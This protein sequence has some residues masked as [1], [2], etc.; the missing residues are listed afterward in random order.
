MLNRIL[1]TSGLSP[2]RLRATARS[3]VITLRVMFLTRSVRST[4]RQHL[5]IHVRQTTSLR[6]LT[7]AAVIA[8]SLHLGVSS[9][10]NGGPTTLQTRYGRI[11]IDEQGF[12]TSITARQSGKEYCPAGHPSPLLSLHE[13]EQPY[14]QLIF[15]KSAAF[16]ADKQQLELKYPNGATAVVKVDA[17]KNYFRF[18]LVSLTPR[19]KVDNIVWGPVHTTISKRIG[20]LIGVVRDNDW[21]IGLYGLD[22][23]TIAGPP[24]DGDCYSMGYYVHS[25]D[26]KKYPLPPDLKEGQKFTIGGDGQSDVAFY[27]RPEEYFHQVFGNGAWLE[28]EFGSTLAYHARDR[29][30]SYVHYFSLLP[31]FHKY[32]RRHMVSDPIPGVDFMGSA[33]ALYACPDDLGLATIETIIKAE[34]LP[35]I[36]HPDGKWIRDP[37]TF[38]PSINWHGPYDKAI[39]YA[40]AIG[41]RAIT[42]ETGESYP[43]LKSTPTVGGASFSDGRKMTG[44]E[45]A[46]MCHN[47][48]LT[49]GGL[50]T[51]TVFLQGGISS[52]VIPPSEHL[53]TVCRTKLAK[54]ISESD[55]EI[56]VTD[57]SFLAEKGTWHWG[58]DSNYLRIGSEMLRYE[59]ISDSPP[60]ILKGIKRGHASKAQ[61]HKAGDEVAKLMQNCYNGFVPDMKLLLDYADWYAALMERSGMD[62]IG[63]DGFESTIYQNHG[64]YGVRVFC[65]RLFETY[66]K[67]TGGR[68]P[69]IYVPSNVF[70]GSWEYMTAC[71]I[72]GGARMF[73]A[74][75]GRR[76]IQGKDVGTAFSNSYF[77]ATLSGPGWHSHWSVYDAENLQAKSIGW[78]ATYVLNM[79]EEVVERTGEK[80][81]IFKALRTWE[82]ARRLNVFTRAQKELL[83]DPDYKFHLEPTGATAFVLHPI[84]EIKI[85]EHA[86][87]EPV[88]VAI[89][90]PYDTQALEFALQ[91]H[92]AVK[93]CIVTLPDGSQIQCDQSMESGQFLIC[94]R[95][96]AYLAD[97]YRKKISDLV[98]DHAAVLPKGESK[99]GV[100]FPGVAK[101]AKV[102]F[103][104]TAWSFATPEKVG[105]QSA[106]L[107]E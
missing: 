68:T 58:D 49:F 107:V 42:R 106:E 73:D 7:V 89:A 59:S 27:S 8:A 75:T 20:D 31:D 81:A 47:H 45:Y 10:A 100:Q 63:F 67:L 46:E 70:A 61:A 72:G 43:S 90:N 36:T 18:Q 78:D 22:D 4:L 26:P 74:A 95:N 103:D 96:Q 6:S 30:Q 101:S 54:D 1:S 28:P 29:R 17:K 79:S 53:Q 102:R 69:Y 2:I 86:G 57:P 65:R 19:G 16:D 48:G 91:V 9:R 99:V 60:W 11:Q 13:Y 50:H 98:M 82:D 76:G 66:S 71:N 92:H 55:T 83:R 84:K 5:P 23:N 77:P 35:Y 21:A 52:D 3:V 40:L 14:E 51:L 94:K 62:I 39:E 93:G 97:K 105:K 38:S 80:D 64:Y 24:V 32:R 87:G 104:L 34:G 15:P 85:S 37:S 88:Q 25:P 41:A 33:V 44:K 12:I 56:V